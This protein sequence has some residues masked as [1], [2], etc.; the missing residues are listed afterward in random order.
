MT[1]TFKTD[2]S[3]EAHDFLQEHVKVN[4]NMLI[5]DLLDKAQRDWDLTNYPWYEDLFYQYQENDIWEVDEDWEGTN[6][7]PPE[8]DPELRE[9]YEYW[10][11]SQ[12]FGEMLKERQALVTNHWGFWLWGRETTGQSIVLDTIF[13]DIWKN[14]Y[15]YKNL[16]AKFN[17]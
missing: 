4:A 17:K 9:P 10:I 8:P 7:C 3:I 16:H 6:Y 2:Q 12:Y 1:P 14:S 13:Q 11:V 15:T 5:Q